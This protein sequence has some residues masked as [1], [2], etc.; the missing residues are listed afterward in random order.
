MPQ[1]LSPSE[2]R[3]LLHEKLDAMLQECDSVADHA[4]WGRTVHD[5]ES[6]C[7]P[8]QRTVETLLEKCSI[9]C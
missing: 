4:A 9:D 3:D 2:V 5:L 8:I 6:L 7:R 1:R